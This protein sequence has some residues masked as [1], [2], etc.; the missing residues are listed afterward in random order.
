MKTKNI[1]N[2]A[3]ILKINHYHVRKSGR[4][5]KIG[6]DCTEIKDKYSSPQSN[7]AKYVLENIIIIVYFNVE[8]D[9]CIIKKP[10]N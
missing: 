7:F 5:L 4:N 6:C 9:L 2:L 1:G 8:N 10:K 3:N